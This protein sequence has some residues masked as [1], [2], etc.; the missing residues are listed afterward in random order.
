M[1]SRGQQPFSESKLREKEIQQAIG[2]L[3]RKRRVELSLSQRA[4]ADQVGVTYQQIQKYEKGD[5]AISVARLTQVAIAL[6]I[7]IS[8]FSIEALSPAPDVLPAPRGRR[9]S[10]STKRLVAAFHKIGNQK[11]REHVLNYVQ[12]LADNGRTP[13]KPRPG[14]PERGLKEEALT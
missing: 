5:C 2:S 7:P 13:P 4:I 9:M 14:E 8:Y 12:S 11:I 10:I 6:G 3:I 1:A